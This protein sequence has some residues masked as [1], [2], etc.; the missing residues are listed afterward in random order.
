MLRNI[1]RKRVAT[2]ALFAVLFGAFSPA[3]ASLIYRGQPGVLAQICSTHGLERIVLDGNIPPAT[4]TQHRIHCAW[5]SASAA[6]PGIDGPSIQT[7]IP[8]SSTQAKP[9]LI[10]TAPIFS[11][12]VASYHPQAPPVLA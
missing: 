1:L 8:A 7:V 4:P 2:I 5:C 12:P 10:K 3:F 11:A 9:A 6:Q